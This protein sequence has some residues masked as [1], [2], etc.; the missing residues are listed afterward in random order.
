[1]RWFLLTAMTILPGSWLTFG[2]SLDELN[3]RTRL[4]LG[5]ALSPIVLAIQLYL[6]RILN[7]DFAPA[8]LVILFINLPCLIL[9]NRSLPRINFRGFWTAFW[10]ASVSLS[11]L[12]GLML[13]L[14]VAIPNFRTVSWHA[15]LHTD[16]IYL[17][18]RN[19]FLPEE[20]DMANIA[21]A[22]PWLDHVYWSITGWLTDWP[23]T[24]VYPISNI[25]WLVI[26]FV[27]AYELASRGLGLQNS[28]AL[29]SAGLTFVGTN[30]IGAMSY[31]VSGKWEFLGDI[32]YT[33]LVGKYFGFET[34]PFALALIVGLSLVCVLLLER[35]TK[36][37]WSLAPILLIALGVVYPVLF[38]VGCLLIAFTMVLLWKNNSQHGKRIGLLLGV[39]VVV[40]LVVFLIYL[41]T[42]TADRSVSTFQFHTLDTFK[43]NTRYAAMAL[44][45]YL[46]LGSPF[47]IRGVLVRRGSTILL[48]LTGLSCIGLY[49][50]VGLSN[51]EYKFILAATLLLMPLAAGGVEILLWQST[52]VRWLLSALTPPVLALFFAFLILKTGVQIPDNLANTPGIIEDSFWL[53]LD[54]KESDSGW[55]EAVRQRTPEDTIVVLHNS[56]IHIA[57]FANR[58]LFFP[59]LGD[60]DAM[61]GY[62]VQKDYYLLQQRGYSKVKFD[63][64]SNTV[65]TLYTP[66]DV[67]RV[68]EAVNA[69][70]K[71]Q[72]PIAIHF[73][74][75]YTPSLLWLKKSNI[76]AE[77]YSDS[78]NIVWFINRQNTFESRLSETNPNGAIGKIPFSDKSHRPISG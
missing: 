53:R 38:S 46:A 62:S 26:T 59:G 10:V 70:L 40:S 2:I 29:I 75:R 48:T 54:K 6:L 28:T 74:D 1:M 64:R 61:A 30:V 16:I 68:A 22:A 57:S 71:L 52:R 73:T 63:S 3:W 58:A 66:S 35:N 43:T 45:P 14:W 44:L 8:V 56:R 42:I 47:I 17:I 4:A 15:L 49:L 67:D 69:L 31:L 77:L 5:A 9:I 72:R 12:I 11:S 55:T 34:M 21:L 27:L 36:W 32:R 60:G 33:P 39:G 20:P 19:P 50:L 18:S 51:L 37:L 76:G 25:I 24:V 7:V 78:K 23:P 13:T 41:S 65:Q